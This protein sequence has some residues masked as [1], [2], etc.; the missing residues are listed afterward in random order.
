MKI[1]KC[2]IKAGLLL[3]ILEILSFSD[4]FLLAQF[5]DLNFYH[6]TTDQ[7][8]S[9]ESIQC[10]YQDSEG[11]MWFA[12]RGGLDRYDGKN[13]MNCYD[14][15]CDTTFSYR[16]IVMA[17]EEDSCG[18]FWF[19]DDTLGLVLLDRRNETVTRF[20]H[21]ENDQ[22]GLSSNKVRAVFEDSRKNLWIATERGL[23]LFNRKDS[24][25]T[26]FLNDPADEQSIA[27]NF[28]TS[29]AE[30]SK[31]FIWLVSP[32]GYLIRYDPA[33]NSFHNLQVFKDPL[34]LPA[35]INAPAIFIDSEDDIW[36]GSRMG[37]HRY[38]QKDK[39]VTLF[40]LSAKTGRIEFPLITSIQEIRKFHFLISTYNNGLFLFQS[41][42]GQFKNFTHSFADVS[43]INS[44][45]LTHI[46]KSAD[47]ILWIGS[48]DN[49]I[50]IYNRYAQRFQKLTDIVEVGY[51][52]YCQHSF[53]SICETPKGKIWLGTEDRGL[54]EFDP[55]KYTIHNIDIGPQGTP[56]F[57]LFRNKADNIWI[58]TGLHGLFLY[59]WNSGTVKKIDFFPG[60][61]R[62]LSSTNVSRVLEDSRNRLWIGYL[63]HGLDL[64]DKRTNTITHFT[65]DDTNKTTLSTD[66][67]FKIF[68]DRQGNVWIGTQ[69]GLNLY[70]SATN[71]IRRIPLPDEK[72]QDSFGSPVYDI[73]QDSF[74]KLWVGSA[75]TLNLYDHDTEKFTAITRKHDNKM[76]GAFSLLED[77]N[78]CI[79][80]GASPGIGK[81]D[82]AKRE[83]THYGFS[84][85]LHHTDHNPSSGLL[86]KNGIMY[87]CATKG[88][89]LFRP[90]NIVDNPFEPPVYITGL[91]IFDVPFAIDRASHL[92]TQSIL[93]DQSVELNHKQSYLTFD[94]AVLNYGRPENNTYAYML[95][96][97]DKNW[98]YSGAS[99]HANYS[100]L[101]PGKYIFK[102][103]ATDNQGLRYFNS[104][105]S[106]EININPPF[107]NT[108]W[109][110]ILA[111]ITASV[112]VYYFY[113]SR[114][115]NLRNQKL[116]LE[117]QI[118]QRT[119][120]LNKANQGLK[121][122]HE[123]LL[124]QNE[125][126]S[127]QNEMLSAMS[128]EILA[129][130]TELEKH[131]TYLEQM[132]T[133]RTEELNRAKLKAEESDRL[134]SAFLANM[135]HEIRTP[136]NAIVGFSNLLKEDK[137]DP[138]EKKEFVNIIN[139]NSEVLLVLIEDI[140][141]LSLIEANQ[142]TIR[143]E[144][145]CLNEI[146][147]N[148][149]SS[150]ALMNRNTDVVIRLNNE[151]HPL[152]L[153]IDS[154]RTR[155][156]QVITNLMNNACKFT[157]KGTI[158]LGLKKQEE[159]LA[160][161][162]KDTGIG[163]KENEL[164]TIFERFRKT[165]DNSHRLY[166]GTGLGLA[167]SRS[168]ATLLGGSLKVESSPGYGS[169]F[170]FLLP[171]SKVVSDKPVA[172][173]NADV[174]NMPRVTGRDV[175]VV[176][177]EKA[178]YLYIKKML[179]KMDIKVHWA[180][181]GKEAVNITSS[182]VRL[183][184]ILMDIKLPVMD[185]FEAARIILSRNPKQV[186]IALTAYAR[187]EDRE[188]FIRAGFTDYLS[189]PINPNDFIN[190]LKKYTNA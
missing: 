3:F 142:L 137:I 39:S 29:L 24:T 74:G 146:L 161:Y 121:D 114:I 67:I 145:I 82:P 20:R 150:F 186:V 71:T 93:N 58:A 76:L 91:K 165:G 88:V 108:W 172:Q 169:V 80:F 49:G 97:H 158:E 98:I 183:D 32:Q 153:A 104:V 130:N 6:L 160:I 180:E 8:L 77:K 128:E 162:V 149:Y 144:I 70:D 25:F 164:D 55:E 57:G 37:L 34:V 43:G 179:E 113:R 141:D 9:N 119:D 99:N 5:P 53:F 110:R 135:S 18:G 17:M 36:F 178:N 19:G 81:Y 123:E 171:Y 95:E 86:S 170:F 54:L 187:A 87:F 65:C 174:A 38:N 189:K 21:N 96:G 117:N 13:F 127:A 190:L 181:N 75:N 143:N 89:T 188:R 79:W 163:I 33:N 27:A 116:T 69:K 118:R 111:L 64:F 16:H 105:A 102:V 124:L 182:G 168:L 138:A 109:F 92:L 156:K 23:N 85:N 4:N 35:Y 60:T 30:D 11:F 120:E 51:N 46:F 184:V 173:I 151:L 167:I 107:W 84:D 176:E 131:R 48:Y 175:L 90:E 31:G 63:S 129:K 101:P 159:Q 62:R 2:G 157:A 1:P 7:G 126:I 132:I 106:L 100:D 28:I 68:E 26:W 45:R 140:L 73:F 139:A 61:S 15:I 52:E 40:P 56:V 50:N 122:Q 112:L 152:N 136:M 42:A 41:K 44:N 83:F 185:G 103:K 148:I 147:D 154:D 22:E 134:K 177:D 125:Q 12:S 115:R 94:F 10:I 47:N 72:G 133:E 166:R 78:H 14:L 155:I 66:D 59:D